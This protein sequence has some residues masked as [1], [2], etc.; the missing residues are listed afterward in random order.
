M[1]DGSG[2]SFIQPDYD[3]LVYPLLLD[4]QGNLYPLKDD[5]DNYWATFDEVERVYFQTLYFQP[6]PADA[7]EFTVSLPMIIVDIPANIANIAASEKYFMIDLGENPQPGQALDLDVTTVIDGQ[8]FH[9]V[10]AEFEGDGTNSLRVTL[11]TDPLNLPSGIYAMS[12]L[13][14]DLEKGAYFGTKQGMNGLP[15]RTFAE[16]IVPPGKSS[17][18]TENIHITGVLNL[19]VSRISYWYRGPFEIPFQFP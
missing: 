5:A 19:E 18:Q 6:V 13:F 15:L 10:K 1:V 4:E 3:S 8:T 2:G 7:K 14:G 16:L 11:Y 12:P 17:G 9:F